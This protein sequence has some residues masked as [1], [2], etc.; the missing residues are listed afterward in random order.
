MKFIILLVSVIVGNN[1][2]GQLQPSDTTFY[3][4]GTIKS[5]W[6][7]KSIRREG[8]I[9]RTYKNSLNPLDYNVP[10][11][12]TIYRWYE[13]SPGLPKEKQ[14]SGRTNIQYP[15][16]ALLNITK[17]YDPLSKSMAGSYQ[18]YFP[19]H[20]NL[21]LSFSYSNDTSLV[22]LSARQIKDSTEYTTRES[23]FLL[24]LKEGSKVLDESPYHTF[25]L[26]ECGF[27]EMHFNKSGLPRQITIYKPKS[28]EGIRYNI[29]PNLFCESYGAI[30]G[31]V[32]HGEW[33]Y[34]HDNGN[35]RSMMNYEW[36]DEEKR[37]VFPKDYEPLE[38]LSNGIKV[39]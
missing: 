37:H 16:G 1:A 27:A 32:E 33:I 39:E 4:N 38:F 10:V 21:L 35:I 25:N 8:P 17:V 24:S 6:F 20:N 13:H 29:Y 18:F 12:D 7:D 14:Y 3:E 11:V 36:N 28:N 34:F 22:S 15:F 23:Y 31:N 30:K 2:I 5:I 19:Q 26:G 9:K